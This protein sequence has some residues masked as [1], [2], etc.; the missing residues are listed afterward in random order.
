M[1]LSIPLAPLFYSSFRCVKGLSRHIL[2][3]F[4][5][6]VFHVPLDTLLSWPYAIWNTS[7]NAIFLI[8]YA[9]NSGD[10]NMTFLYYAI[11][12]PHFSPLNLANL[13]SK[14]RR[15]SAHVLR[16]WLAFVELSVS[17]TSKMS[18]PF[19]SIPSSIYFP[20]SEIRIMP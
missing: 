20:F 6:A 12:T 4:A 1:H 2:R 7:M 19:I 14:F 9:T 5:C 10:D 13:P 17:K 8:V 11:Q 18:S 16:Q 3:A 15:L